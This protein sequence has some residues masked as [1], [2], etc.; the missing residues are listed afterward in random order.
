M[1]R[2]DDLV[3]PGAQQIGL[4]AVP[5]LFRPHRIAP[6]PAP[7]A[8]E[9]RQTAPRNLQDNRRSIRQTLQSQTLENRHKQPETRT[10]HQTS[11]T[12]GKLGKSRTFFVM[13]KERGDFRLPSDLLD[14]TPAE[15]DAT[16]DDLSAALGA[17]CSLMRRNINQ[18]ALLWQIGF[19]RFGGFAEGLRAVWASR[20][21]RAHEASWISAVS[22]IGGPRCTRVGFGERSLAGP[23]SETVTARSRLGGAR[24]HGGTAHPK[25]AQGVV[26]EPPRMAEKAHDWTRP[27]S[28]SPLRPSIL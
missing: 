11:R 14:V 18:L 28:Y 20:G 16:R 2:V 17:A 13:S 27:Q 19:F 7:R 10:N 21:R 15:F 25:H 4:T 1:A 12:T 26:L 9:S 22:C 3:E 5:P 8:K 24:R 6:P 23:P